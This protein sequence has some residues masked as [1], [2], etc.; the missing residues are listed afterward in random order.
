MKRQT[1]QL[2][3]LNA[4][5]LERLRLRIDRLIQ[6]L[7][8]HLIRRHGR[9]PGELIQHSR[10]GFEDAFRHIDVAAALDDFA[11]DELGDFGHGVVF[12]AVELE[13]LGGG[14]VV[15]E[16]VFEGLADVDSLGG[17]CV[18]FRKGF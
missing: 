16:H 9:P 13:G 10:N 18:R 3:R 8:L 6:K 4:Q 17:D 12:R 14:G 1:A 7:L 11:V 5:I 2:R 15:L